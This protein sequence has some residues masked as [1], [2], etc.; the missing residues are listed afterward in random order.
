M[1]CY[2]KLT[3]CIESP[4]I[5]HDVETS[6]LFFWEGVVNYLIIPHYRLQRIVNSR[7]YIVEYVTVI[8]NSF[9]QLS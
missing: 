6:R 4:V 5:P 9:I 1:V 7:F 3:N 8:G 2:V